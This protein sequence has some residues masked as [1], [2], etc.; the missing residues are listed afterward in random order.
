MILPY[1]RRESDDLKF[2]E[3]FP[4]GREETGFLPYGIT[5]QPVDVG[6]DFTP[7][8]LD[9]YTVPHTSIQVVK[10]EVCEDGKNAT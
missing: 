4:A 9:V 2:K 3:V 5:S 1:H 6:S 8:R 7:E 10:W